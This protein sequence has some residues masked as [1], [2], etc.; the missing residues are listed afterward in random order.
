MAACLLHILLLGVETRALSEEQS[1]LSSRHDLYD[2]SGSS[3]LIGMAKHMLGLHLFCMSSSAII[4]NNRLWQGHAG[5][6][7]PGRPP[8][9]ALFPSL[10]V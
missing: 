2:A 6:K 10:P 4:T 7:E 3:F 8:H 5:C 1:Q 9:V